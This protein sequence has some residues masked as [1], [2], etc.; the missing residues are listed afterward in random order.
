MRVRHGL[1]FGGALFWAGCGSDKSDGETG[2]VGGDNT[3][4]LELA[5]ASTEAGEG[6]GYTLVLT[7]SDGT[8]E[9]V[10][11]GVS[12]DLDPALDVASDQLVATVAGEHTL[13][14]SADVDGQALTAT[15]SLTVDP[16][17]V[18]DLDLVL[19]E[20]S[21]SAG[22]A[23][24]YT[25]VAVD[26]YG[27]GIDVSAALVSGTGLS[28]D[29]CCDAGVVSATAVGSYTLDASFDDH[30]DSEQLDVV[31]AAGV[32]IELS[33]SDEA[34][35]PGDSTEATV[36]VV[37]AWGNSSSDPWTLSATGGAATIVGATVTVD[38]EGWY[39]V[40]ATLDSG[41]GSDSVGPLLVDQSGPVLV[42][43]APE[44][45][46]WLAIGADTG[47]GTA[48]D[49]VAG[50]ASVTQDENASTLDETGA[51]TTALSWDFGVN[52]VV[53]LA[54]DT[55]NNSSEDVRSL[56]AGDVLTLAEPD[57][58][59]LVV[60]IHEGE[61][62][63]GTLADSMGELVDAE[64][65]LAAIPSPAISESDSDC[66]IVFGVEVCLTYSLT[67]KFTDLDWASQDLELDPQ[68]D[69]TLLA[70]LTLTDLEA[71]YS[72]TG[73]LASSSSV[74]PGTLTASTL[75]VSVVLT[76][77]VDGGSVVLTTGDVT[78]SLTDFDSGASSWMET[79]ATTVGFDIEAMT[80]DALAD[81]ISDELEDSLGPAL[82]DSLA[83]LSFTQD[84]TLA[85][86][87]V[88]ISAEPA[89][90]AVDDTG[91][92]LNLA[93]E[94]N[95]EG[96]GL[97]LADAPLWYGWSSPTWTGTPGM[98]MA[99][100]V[101]LVNRLLF[102]AW[103]QGEMEFEV[104]A[105][106]LGVAPSMVKL[107]LPGVTDAWFEVRGL[108]PPMVV[109]GTG[110]GMLDFQLGSLEFNIYEGEPA[111][112]DLVYQ[113]YLAAGAGLDLELD[114]DSLVST[115]GTPVVQADVTLAPADASVADLE[116]LLELML[117]GVLET[118]L[119]VLGEFPLPTISGL[120]WAASSVSMEG[121]E[122]GYCGVGG[123][124]E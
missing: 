84:L 91:L 76:P 72:A 51:F 114:G 27:N 119:A 62:G 121:A 71:D 18:D 110:A 38:E 122:R 117:P 21:A 67:L 95:N 59:S 78:V 57:D 96:T 54:V 12:S 80:E 87:V 70:T 77:S 6:V 41:A 16:G 2:G 82:E 100:S 40:T 115:L 44:R 108:L 50:V 109:P 22:E 30:D 88:T 112:D 68:A 102:A 69:G 101:N 33:L 23:V 89:A 63:L 56:M 46:A 93:T 9:E 113:A 120:D 86:G 5:S 49:A 25:L 52:T 81:A 29:G 36:V 19:A 118:E 48:V 98:V 105:I 37:D 106:D 58:Q 32:Q 47:S 99:L 103:D 85:E 3:L 26:A 28:V 83:D 66:G 20:S 94:L 39:T 64:T 11:G 13:T 124:L 74:T 104:Q 111:G 43:D 4:T 34:L 79:V 90:I 75:E 17:P 45:S 14:A 107:L 35:E 60:R 10:S 116:A 31:A 53:T 65:A 61:G 42:V 97:D 15:A 1:V 7:H 24:G 123:E 92:T 73:K 8:S 55:D